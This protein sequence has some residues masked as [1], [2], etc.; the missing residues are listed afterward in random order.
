VIAPVCSAGVKIRL[1][2]LF[3]ADRKELI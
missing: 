3:P 1:F 2:L